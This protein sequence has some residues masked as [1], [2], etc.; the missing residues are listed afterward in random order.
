MAGSAQ[1]ILQRIVDD[2]G[3]ATLAGDWDGY[4]GHV[5]LP[6]TLQTGRATMVI[7]TEDD[8]RAGFAMF[9]EMIVVQKVTDLIRIVETA[10][11]TGPD[12]IEGSYVSHLLSHAHR[13]VPPFRSTMLLRNVDGHWRIPRITNSLNNESWPLLTPRPPAHEA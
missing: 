8:L 1:D 10:E 7:E 13:V 2:V 5:L 6:F 11:F 12:A 4:A 9:H 3:A